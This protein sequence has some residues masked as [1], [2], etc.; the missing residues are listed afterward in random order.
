MTLAGRV[1]SFIVA[2]GLACLAGPLFLAGCSSSQS[3]GASNDAAATGGAAATAGTGGGAG[4]SSGAG[5]AGGGAA[6]THGTGGATGGTSGAAGAAGSGAAGTHG[7]GGA[8]GG[9]SGAAGAA[10]SGAAGAHGTGGATGGTGGGAGAPATTCTGQVIPSLAQPP[11]TLAATVDCWA[12][13]QLS[14][15]AGPVTDEAYVGFTGNQGGQTDTVLATIQKTGVSFDVPGFN[16]LQAIVLADTTGGTEL[17]GDELDNQGVGYFARSG[18]S[19]QREMVSPI[20][21]DSNTFYRAWGAALG[22]DGQPRVLFGDPNPAATPLVLAQRASSDSWSNTQI[23]G[24]I[25][26]PVAGVPAG[27]TI[28]SKGLAHVFYLQP[29]GPNIPNS[30]YEWVEGQTAGSLGYAGWTNP[31]IPTT[32]QSVAAGLGGFVGVAGLS[33]SGIAV[34]FVDGPIAG[35]HQVIAG[36]APAGCLSTACTAGTCKYD[37]I[38]SPLAL[39]ATSDGAFWLAYALDHIDY[40]YTTSHNANT[41]QETATTTRSTE[42]V[43]LVRMVA[44]GSTAATTKWRTSTPLSSTTSLGLASKGSR[45]YLAISERQIR[46][47]ALDWASL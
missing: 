16:A 40:D 38:G 18:S 34:M 9:T 5:T 42:E 33:G 7:T 15:A 8:T 32:P 23:T 30:L 13:F 24:P 41:C 19:W 3:G 31:A 20:P 22:A 1:V 4:G 43:V 11:V 17:V 45:L 37:Q 12:S 6:G 25:D 21:T 27:M 39:T 26:I 36:T 46:V 14:I 35:S 10:G 29:G 2:G 44:D 47:F 28:D